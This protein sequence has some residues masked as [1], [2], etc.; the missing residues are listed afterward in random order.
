MDRITTDRAVADGAP[1]AA[2]AAPVGAAGDGLVV[3]G[4]SH[5]YGAVTVVDAVTLAVPRGEV[6][7]LMGPSGCGKTTT[8]R[9][10]AGLERLQRGSIELA[11]R[12]LAAPGLMLPPESRQIGLMFQDLALFPHLT[13][14]ENVAFGLRRLD[15]A[16]RRQR[17]AALI[18]MVGM[19]RHAHKYPDQLSGGEQQRIALARALAPR[20]QLMLLDEAFSA[21]DAS[22]RAE[23]RTDSLEILREQG[24]PTL[25]VTHD[26]EEAIVAG[27]RVHVMQAG[28]LVQSGPAEALYKHPANG[29]IAE[30]FG[31]T[32]RFDSEVRGGLAWTPLGMIAAPVQPDGQPVEVVFRAEALH[33]HPE[34]GPRGRVGQI[35]DCRRMGPACELRIALETGSTIRVRKPVETPHH[36]GM[37]IGL[38]IDQRYTFVFAKGAAD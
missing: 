6:H 31:P 37:R 28:R 9:L 30:F 19:G 7:C 17:V 16:T 36:L 35:V 13:V 8:L 26:P 20:P 5:R 18:A 32:V 10:I 3:R 4:L 23:I 24:V 1:P 29:F 21:L 14:E 11:G 34:P 27:D 2:D 15:A 12:L 25:L 38:E 33:L 22:L